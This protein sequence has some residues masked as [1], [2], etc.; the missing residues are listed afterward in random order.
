MKFKTLLEIELGK[1]PEFEKT[2]EGRKKM[3]D[4]KIVGKRKEEKKILRKIEKRSDDMVLGKL[5][6]V[7]PDEVREL[8]RFMEY[9]M[10]KLKEYETK[11][12]NVNIPIAAIPTAAGAVMSMMSTSLTKNEM[13][14]LEGVIKLKKPRNTQELIQLITTLHSKET[15][16]M[17]KEDTA[18]G[19]DI[20]D[21]RIFVRKVSKDPE[22]KRRYAKFRKSLDR[23]IG[24]KAETEHLSSM[25]GTK[26]I[27]L[28]N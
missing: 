9:A 22:L 12:V 1:D 7:S 18:P 14:M 8:V 6:Q 26:K 25:K 16:S 4:K 19:L 11:E 20:E 23:L 2:I 17:L 21:L 27:R 5:P 13:K 3:F 24:L 15:I 28:W 10:S